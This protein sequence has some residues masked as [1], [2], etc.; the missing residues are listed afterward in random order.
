MYISCWWANFKF[1]ISSM[2]LFACSF[3]SS[4][5]FISWCSLSSHSYLNLSF[6]RAT[7]SDLFLR[8][9]TCLFI[10][11][12]CTLCKFDSSSLFF[13]VRG[14]SCCYVAI[15]CCRR[16]RNRDI[17]FSYTRISLSFSVHLRSKTSL[18]SNYAYIKRSLERK[19][20]YLWFLERAGEKW[21]S[22]ENEVFEGWRHDFNIWKFISLDC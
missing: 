11:S 13:D 22:D 3:R 8:S 17:S 12:I 14:S 6:S 7:T 1:S 19:R 2:C 15:Y 16:D 5:N 10:E 21:L 20:V 18:S 4:F 9:S